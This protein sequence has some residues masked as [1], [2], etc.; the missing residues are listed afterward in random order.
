V[1][2]GD[3]REAPAVGLDLLDGAA[4]RGAERGD[5]LWG[6]RGGHV[7]SCS[8]VRLGEVS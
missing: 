5:G 8:F 3:D 6:V 1:V 4:L 2:G 7:V